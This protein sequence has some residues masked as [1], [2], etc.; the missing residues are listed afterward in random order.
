MVKVSTKAFM[1]R[2]ALLQTYLLRFRLHLEG[3]FLVK[4]YFIRDAAIEALRLRRLKA[5]A[6]E[7][8]NAMTKEIWRRAV[9]WLI[10]L[11]IVLITA[12][13]VAWLVNPF[14]HR[15]SH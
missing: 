7:V 14:S 6:Q 3:Q 8:D 9:R 1:T 4:L 11:L 13:A 15:H 2:V 10:S 5:S 12:I